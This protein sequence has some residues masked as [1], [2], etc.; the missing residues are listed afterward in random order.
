[1]AES[2]SS[3]VLDALLK[4]GGPE[5]E[6][7]SDEA[8]SKIH[9]TQVWKYR[10]GRRKP[11]AETIARLERLSNGRVPANGWEDLSVAQ[12]AEFAAQLARDAAAQKLAD[13]VTE[14]TTPPQTVVAKR[15]S[16][17]PAGPGDAAEPVAMP[18]QAAVPD[19]AEE[20]ATEDDLTA[21]VVEATPSNLRNERSDTFDEGRGE[22]LE[23]SPKP[24]TVLD[25]VIDESESQAPPR[26]RNDTPAGAR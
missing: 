10:T 19:L 15:N 23:P 24:L 20:P 11:D 2:K 25:R 6:A 7:I 21:P 18:P 22:T 26:R 9:R 1:M 13:A 14:E 3:I 5:A 16:S 4:A 17:R 12:A 8:T